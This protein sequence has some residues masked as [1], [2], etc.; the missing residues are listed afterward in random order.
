MRV[1]GVVDCGLGL[2]GVVGGEGAGGPAGWGLPRREP[3]AR[4][5][6]CCGWFGA[7]GSVVGGGVSSSA[8]SRL[9]SRLGGVFGLCLFGSGDLLWII[10]YSII[11]S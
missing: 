2:V 1:A 9:G 3:T 7:V 8:V 10:G 5:R 6:V 11:S 4:G